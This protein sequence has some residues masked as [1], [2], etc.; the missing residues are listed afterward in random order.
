MSFY[1]ANDIP[2]LKD[3]ESELIN[4]W[5][6][7]D[8][9][10]YESNID[11]L[12]SL[13][14]PKTKLMQVVKADAYG[15]GAIHIAKKAE[16]IGVSYLGVAN[17]A[18]GKILR[19]SN[20]K[21]PILVLASIFEN[22]IEYAIKNDLHITITSLESILEIDNVAFKINKI[23]K[24]HLKIDTGMGRVGIREENIDR[25]IE[26]LKQTK[27]ISLDGV[28]THFAESEDLNSNFTNE[29]ITIFKKA[30]EK[31]KNAGFQ[32][33]ITHCA[34]SSAILVQPESHF[35]MVRIGIAGYGIGDPIKEKL[36]QILTLKSK[37]INIKKV[38]KNSSLGYKRSFFTKKDSTM[39]IIPIGYADGL[40]RI[41]SNNQN[42]IINDEFY[43][44]CGNISMDQ[45]VIDISDSQNDIL[46]RIKIGDEIILLG[47]SKSKNIL[48]EEWARKSYKITY[49]VLCSFGNRLPRFYID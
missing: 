34:N 18:E 16:E 21:L 20:I 47:E 10:K 42:V 26:L 1:F 15:H 24:T 46:S 49:E 28:F 48:I 37:V 4:A 44:I 3:L 32:D 31:I 7:I 6:E 38:P 27:N 43:P 19:L 41:L 11:Y 33:F 22:Q 13:L 35:D 39:A 12:K 30:I 9:K 14:H 40:P 8:L 29:Q 36:Q 17:I 5:L 25:A 23:A 45:C 2:Y